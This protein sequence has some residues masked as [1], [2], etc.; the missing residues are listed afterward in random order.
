MLKSHFIINVPAQMRSEN[1]SWYMG[2]ADAIFQNIN[3][4][5][6]SD[7]HLTSHPA[8]G[9]CLELHLRTGAAYS[10]GSVP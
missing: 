9:A 1:E 2:T 7:P 8:S 10:S 4:I 5:E 3:L 6:Q